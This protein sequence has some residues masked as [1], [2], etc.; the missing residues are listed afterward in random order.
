MPDPLAPVILAIDQGTTSTRAII[1]DLQGHPRHT[2]QQELPQHY[3]G[4]GR[5]EHDPD[6]IWQATLAT[7]RTAIA[8]TD[9][10]ASPA[11]IGITNQRE[12]ILIWDRD[13]GRPIH[14]AIVWQDRR[15]APL[16]ARLKQEGL[17][18]L[19]QARTGLLLDPYFSATKLAWLLD[20]VEGARTAAAH[21]RLAAG[22]IDT[23]L[24]WRLT[25]GQVHATDATNASRTLLFDI[26][27]QRWD[28]DLLRLF[29]IPESLLPRVLDN[30]ALF[31]TTANGLLPHQ[32]AIT[33]MAGDQQA[34][35]IGQS[36][37]ASGMMKAT[38][39]TG[40]FALCH[41][42]DQARSSTHRM[43]ATVASRLQG[44]PAYAIE[45]AIFA[46]GAAIK[47][48]R[49]GLHLI[50]HAAETEALAQSLPDTH[51]VYLVPGF[52]G[53]GAPHWDP[54]ARGLI[55]GLTLDT[56]KAHLARAALEATA[57]QTLDLV[58]AMAADAG[59]AP[60]TLRID[61]GM[62]NN[63]FLSQ[64]LA[65]ILDLPVECPANPEITA[66]GAALLAALGAGLVPHLDIPWT[67]ERRFEP[68]MP[69]TTRTRLIAGWHEALAR[70]TNQP[71]L[72]PANRVT[73]QP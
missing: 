1:F 28:D 2:A 64:F 67:A 57:Y 56:T 20:H 14:P 37:L 21:G 52:T 61:G 60:K 55:A 5:V 58:A 73:P 35:L 29:D 48:L 39:G 47:W 13:T 8:Q 22:T 43:L 7:T 66:W 51:G 19:I 31:G 70:C 38:Y 63:H 12:T 65:D 24:L 27:H 32:I 9:P 23:F 36:C 59:T 49:D 72:S 71:Q 50:D 41:T 33:G 40:C 53:L 4:E 46:A 45:G 44:R 62:T 10:A 25:G 6:D 17:E 34:A 15:T 11:A 30:A 16:C 26:H 54:A 18:P 69:P 42:G 3:P 68:T